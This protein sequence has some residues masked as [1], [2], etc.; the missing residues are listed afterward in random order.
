MPIPIDVSLFPC[1]V[2]FDFK[3]LI[4]LVWIFGCCKSGICLNS[5]SLIQIFL[6]MKCVS[7]LTIQIHI[8]VMFNSS[9][10][11]LCW[12]V[13]HTANWRNR[14]EYNREQRVIFRVFH[15]IQR[16]YLMS[17]KG[18]VTTTTHYP[19]PGSNTG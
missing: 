8:I 16:H 12:L 18:Y 19:Y 15:G 5:T 2:V 10:N 9:Q 11:E 17:L 3:T 7:Y 6:E 1:F 13:R 14:N 4:G